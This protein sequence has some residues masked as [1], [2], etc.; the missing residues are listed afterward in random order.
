[1]VAFDS[2]L[3]R[4][5]MGRFATGITVATTRVGAEL[6]GMTANAV[7]SLS[8]DPPLVL[9]CVE[10]RAQFLAALKESG[11]YALSILNEEQE[12][13]SRRFAQKGPKDFS[14]LHTT[15]A[16]T[17]S[18]ILGDAL[19]WIDCK[20]VDVLPG[21]D[22]EIFIGEIVAGD[23]RDGRPLLYFSGNYAKLAL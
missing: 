12:A 17:G 16:V 2:L 21:G 13:V 8:L 19:G 23:C 4:R 3:Q 5:I 7:T 10:K 9:L 22:H 11:C 6:F 15:T 14:D 18:P 1:L 20:V